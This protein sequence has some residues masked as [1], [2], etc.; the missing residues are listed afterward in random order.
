MTVTVL[1]PTE[2]VTDLKP[3]MKSRLLCIWMNTGMDVAKLILAE[4]V[5]KVVDRRNKYYI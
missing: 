4:V 2:E 1:P 5:G 3:L